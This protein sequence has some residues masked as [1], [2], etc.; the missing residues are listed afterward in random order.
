[1]A[2]NRAQFHKDIGLSSFLKEYGAEE[3]CFDA[4]RRWRWPDGFRHPRCGHDK[5]RDP[6]HREPK[7]CNRCRRQ[8]SITSRTIFDSNKHGLACFNF[9]TEADKVVCGGGAA[10]PLMSRSSIG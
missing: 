6:A 10:F 3:Q 1:M 4:L 5:H 7:R 2:R 9:V 8:T